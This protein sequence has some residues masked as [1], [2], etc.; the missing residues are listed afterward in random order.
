MQNSSFKDH[1]Y[2]LLDKYS[3]WKKSKFVLNRRKLQRLAKVGQFPSIMIISCCDS[4]VHA[5]EIFEAEPGEL[6]IHRN[7]ANLIPPHD[8]HS[9]NTGTAA[10]LEFAVCA[11]KSISHYY[12][13]TLRMW[14][15]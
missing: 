10:A 2:L 15:N 1:L 3:N 12:F 13:R 5:S 6:F 7:I 4:R 8:T 9:D 11:L 14:W